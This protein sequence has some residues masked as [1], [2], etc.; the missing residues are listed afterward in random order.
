MMMAST[1]VPVWCISVV[2]HPV[3]ELGFMNSV[4]V[5]AESASRPLLLYESS[6]AQ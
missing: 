6:A 1:V 5:V 4:V 3:K 2:V